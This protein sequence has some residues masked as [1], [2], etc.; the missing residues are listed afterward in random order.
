M[1]RQLEQKPVIIKQE[2]LEQQIQ[3]VT[4]ILPLGYNTTCHHKTG[5]CRAANTASK[6]YT[7]SGL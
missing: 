2:P 6:D 7:F 4:I 3:Q 1:Y 5:T